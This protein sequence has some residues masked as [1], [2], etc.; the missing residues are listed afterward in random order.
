MNFARG[1]GVLLH[2]SSLPGR[3][4]IGDLG[5]G[6][7]EFIDFLADS[8]QKYWQFLPIG[9]TC[10]IS[11][12][13]PYMSFSAFAGNPLL[14]DPEELL[15]EG[16]LMRE[17]FT[18]V[19][20]F[21]EYLV[22][23]DR[24]ALCKAEM[25]GKAWRSFC[26]SA[27]QDHGYREFCEKAFWLNDYALFMAIKEKYQ[28]GPWYGWPAEIAGRNEAALKEEAGKLSGRIGYHRFVQYCFHRQWQKMKAYAS[29]KGVSLVG[30]MPIYVAH[31]SVDVWANPDC[32]LLDRKTLALTHVAGVPPDYFSDTGQRWGNPLYRWQEKR[33][34]VNHPLYEWWVKRFQAMFTI[35]DICRIDHFRGF[36]SCWQIAASEKTAVN[37][38][39]LKG[40][41]LDFFKAMQHELGDLPIIAEDLGI[42]TPEVIELREKLQFPGMKILQFAFD[43]DAGNLYLPHNF[44]DANCVVFTGT[45]DNDTTLGWFL[46]DKLS[47]PV[48]HKI[49]KYANSNGSGIHR[50]MI[51]LAMS[52]VANI[53]IYPMQDLLGFG[54]DC[55]MN[56]PG[57]VAGNWRWRCASRF[58]TDELAQWL[59]RETEFYNRA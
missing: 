32:F 55:R 59:R 9:P 2:I 13:S 16:L 24:V 42:I 23:F 29:S 22:D 52:S 26:E 14:I 8:R 36:E 58:I 11:A 51:R 25:L 6:A 37:G 57:T 28:S 18:Y 27:D 45:H 53:S 20:D 50:D 5:R 49:L 43:S 48:R 31:D 44:S 39:W 56:T 10:A 30:D 7:Y 1:S 19:P 3:F 33:G 4:G 34:V 17:D 40:P 15:A 21:S 12:N 47:E 54:T 41:G 38:R 46:S 35:S